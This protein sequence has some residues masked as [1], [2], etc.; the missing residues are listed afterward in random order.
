MDVTRRKFL[1]L[2]TAAIGGLALT[3]CKNTDRRA[4]SARTGYIDAHSHIWTPDTKRFP[5]GPWITPD[6]MEPASFT[7]EQL[8]ATAEPCGVDR[9]VLIQHAPYYGDDHSYLIHCA[10]IFPGRFSIVAMVDERRSDL[11]EH[12]RHLKQQGVRGIRIGPSRYA[13]RTLVKEPLHWLK[14]PAMRK[15]WA[16]A[17]DEGLLLCPLLNAEQLPTLDPMLNEFPNTKIVI[18]HFGHADAEKPAELQALLKLAEHRQVHVKV[19]GFYKFGDRKAPYED[20]APLIKH[21]VKAYTPGRLLWGSD[22]P[23]QLQNGNDYKSA[24]ALIES[25]LDFLDAPARQAILR[26][27]AQRLFFGEP[28]LA[29]R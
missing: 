2:G 24:V 20:L 21:V 22:C 18:D 27:N 19:S 7:A 25:G 3:G 23:Y 5:L 26:D 1:A 9:V 8:L 15:L 14:A 13:D 6:K 16:L 12:L 29:A 11:G 4:P 28:P 10:K 17:A